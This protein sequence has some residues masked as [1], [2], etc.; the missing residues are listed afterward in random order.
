MSDG[1]IRNTYALRLRNKQ[2]QEHD[3][4]VSVVAAD[5][6]TPDGVSVVLEGQP[7]ARIRVAPDATQTQRLYLTAAPGSGFAEGGQAEIVLWVE[8]LSDGAKSHVNTVFHGRS[9]K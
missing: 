7:D 5:G 6:T 4:A 2:G 1:A 9:E 8:D 3:F